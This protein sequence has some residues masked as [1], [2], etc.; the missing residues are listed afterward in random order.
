MDKYSAT[1]QC[2]TRR[3][4]VSPAMRI[5]ALKHRCLLVGASQQGR[6]NASYMSDPNIIDE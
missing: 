3:T 4:Y 5:V 6:P 2:R 1:F